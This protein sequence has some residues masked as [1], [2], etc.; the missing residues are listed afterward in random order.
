VDYCRI[1]GTS[2]VRA[3]GVVCDSCVG[4]ITARAAGRDVDEN[5]PAVREFDSEFA[6]YGTTSSP[7]TS[8]QG[9]CAVIAFAVAAVPAVVAALGVFRLVA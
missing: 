9:G 6:K 4:K 7:R 8:N 5:D 3:A 2:P 1:C